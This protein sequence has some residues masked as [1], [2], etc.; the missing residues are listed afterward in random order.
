MWQ[1]L[2]LIGKCS[3][4]VVHNRGYV[5]YYWWHLR[6]IGTWCENPRGALMCVPLTTYTAMFIEV[7]CTTK[8]WKWS[9]CPWMTERINTLWYVQSSR[10]D[11]TVVI[12]INLDIFQIAIVQK[13][14]VAEEH[15]WI[16]SLNKVN[17]QSPWYIYRYVAQ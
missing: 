17:F 12:H 9:N 16:N 4:L 2:Y 7:F 15:T 13:K 10:C 14:Q 6:L 1:Y 8:T 3:F 5:P 11:C